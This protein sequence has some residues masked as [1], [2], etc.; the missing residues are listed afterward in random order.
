MHNKKRWWARLQNTRLMRAIR[1]S[2]KCAQMKSIK[3]SKWSNMIIWRHRSMLITRRLWKISRGKSWEMPTSSKYRTRSK[4]PI[5]I[6]LKM[7]DKWELHLWELVRDMDNSYPRCKR[8]IDCT[9]MRLTKHSKMG[10]LT[11]ESKSSQEPRTRWTT[12]WIKTGSMP[13]LKCMLTTR[14]IWSMSIA[15]NWETK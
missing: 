5:S 9:Q 14:R 12:C 4:W 11:A 6:T 3:T 8:E 1:K 15:S 7:P 10:T 2:T 13:D